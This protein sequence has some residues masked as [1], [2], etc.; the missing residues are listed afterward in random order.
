MARKMLA[1]E[2]TIL[3]PYR[4]PGI[5]VELVLFAQQGQSA[6]SGGRPQQPDGVPIDDW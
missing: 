2:I 1:P 4:S 3:N 6:W 5:G